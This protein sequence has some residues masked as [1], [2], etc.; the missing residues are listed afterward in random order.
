M[1]ETAPV[2]LCGFAEVIQF[3]LVIDGFEFEAEALG[4]KIAAAKAGDIEA[5]V[6]QQGPFALGIFFGS[7]ERAGAGDVLESNP[8]GE[9]FGKGLVEASVGT[10]FVETGRGLEFG[11][12]I[13]GL[14]CDEPIV[15]AAISPF[16]EVDLGNRT[17]IEMFGEDGFD[18]G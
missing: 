10:L 3:A 5:K 4:S 2:G 1:H 12:E 9:L 7:Q 15:V 8:V 11:D 18:L 16:A 14:M 13:E 17:G 6:A